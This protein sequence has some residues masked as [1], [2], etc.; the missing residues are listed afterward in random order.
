MTLEKMDRLSVVIITRNEENN[1]D[2]CL[3]SVKDIADEIVVVDAMSTDKTVEICKKYGAK[4][5]EREWDDF[6]SQKNYAND[7]ATEEYIFSID[8]DEELTEELKKSILRKKADGLG[9]RIAYETKRLTYFCGNPV[10]HCGWYPDKKVRLWKKSECRWKGLVHEKLEFDMP[11]KT[12]TLNGD[13]NHYTITDLSQQISKI[14]T[15]A[16]YRIET[17]EKENKLYKPTVFKIIMKP[18]AKFISIYFVKLGILDGYTGY[19]I[20]KNSAFARFF[21][22]SKLRMIKK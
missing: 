7:K 3:R 10:K 21:F 1:I 14:M 18:I 8:A 16:D 15:Y 12:E 2:R 6:S 22:L 13:L 11:V 17:L 5:Y 9:E 20:A 19:V 4:V